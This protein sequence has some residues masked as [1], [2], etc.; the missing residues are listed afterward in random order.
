MTTDILISPE[1]NV[2]KQPVAGLTPQK[3]IFQRV[4]SQSATLC[5]ELCPICQKEG[6]TGTCGLNLGHTQEHQCNRNSSHRW[7]SSETPDVPG[8]H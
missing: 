1:Q 6:Q 7:T 2:T 5:S 3:L 4:V 8:P